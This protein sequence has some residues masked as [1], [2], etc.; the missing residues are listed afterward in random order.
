MRR[1]ASGMCAAWRRLPEK[2]SEV[3]K[4]TSEVFI[5]AATVSGKTISHNDGMA[6][7]PLR[8]LVIDDDKNLAASIAASLSTKGHACT[9]ATSGKAGAAKIDDDD[10]DVV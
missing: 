10:F 1:R 9:V 8:V 5:C 4:L 6:A 2:T 3:P 7:D